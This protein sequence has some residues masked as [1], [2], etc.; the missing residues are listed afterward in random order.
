MEKRSAAPPAAL[1]QSLPTE[2]AVP[3]AV[4]MCSELAVFVK[5]WL[6]VSGSAPGVPAHCSVP[7]HPQLLHLEFNTFINASCV[8]ESPI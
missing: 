8:L 5:V 1:L 3:P 7:P 4:S 6:S 2:Q